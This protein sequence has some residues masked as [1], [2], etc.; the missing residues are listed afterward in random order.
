[1]I[2]ANTGGRLWFQAPGNRYSYANF[3]DSDLTYSHPGEGGGG[4][5]HFLF[6]C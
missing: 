6:P 4:A 5:K 1:M 3:L 2:L